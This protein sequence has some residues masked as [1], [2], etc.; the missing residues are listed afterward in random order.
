MEIHKDVININQISEE[1]SEESRSTEEYH[2]GDVININL[3]NIERKK[4]KTL[5]YKDLEGFTEVKSKYIKHFHGS[6]LKFL[7][8]KTNQIYQG[9]FLDKIIHNVIYLR[10][11]S[12]EN[13]TVSLYENTFYIKVINENYIS[14]LEL[15]KEH[16]KQIY[17]ENIKYK[18]L[19]DYKNNIIN[20]I[21][22]GNL[23]YNFIKFKQIISL[24]SIG[25]C[26]IYIYFLC[27]F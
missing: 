16:E 6:W 22:C 5:N 19:L 3:Q 8:K 11:P 2:R 18:E 1:E 7:N 10:C 24:I 21:N 4:K 9:G 26:F 27:V 14:L 25:K 12:K 20:M 13:L 15:L 17:E 23:I